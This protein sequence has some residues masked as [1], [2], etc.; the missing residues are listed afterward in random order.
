[1]FLWNSLIPAQRRY[2]INLSWTLAAS[3]LMLSAT[4]S[5]LFLLCAT[6]DCTVGVLSLPSASSLSSLIDVTGKKHVVQR[7]RATWMVIYKMVLS[8]L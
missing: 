2:G 7:E 3:Y 8:Y 5:S 4:L 1:M 6:V